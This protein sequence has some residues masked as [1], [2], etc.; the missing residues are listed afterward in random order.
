[1]PG[2]FSEGRMTSV[3]QWKDS[4]KKTISL[5]LAMALL[6]RVLEKNPNI[7]FDLHLHGSAHQLPY[8]P[9]ERM[10]EEGTATISLGL[11]DGEALIFGQGP[12]GRVPV[13]VAKVLVGAKICVRLIPFERYTCDTEGK[14][15]LIIPWMPGLGRSV[16]VSSLGKSVQRFY[17]QASADITEFFA[18]F[19]WSPRH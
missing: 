18:P 17:V 6:S 2:D 15:P 1:M 10:D 14:F 12:T 5:A 3:D 16:Q 13:I 4:I 8:R 19:V 7:A 11:R 9:G